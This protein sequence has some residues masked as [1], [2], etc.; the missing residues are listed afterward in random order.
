MLIDETGTQ[1]GAV[2]TYEAL[3]RARTAGLD[4]VEVAPAGR[5]P[6]CRIMDYGKYKYRQKKK[7]H[8]SKVSSHLKEVRLTPKIQEHDLLIKA[9]HAKDF[10]S[11][12]HK[13][14]VSMVFKGRE[15]EHMELGTNMLGVFTRSLDGICK[16]EAPA[17][18]E[19]KKLFLM[20]IPK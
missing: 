20:L 5:P 11:K 12:G 10:L 9:D 8:Q 13:V 19:G 3:N 1:I 2:D 14:L 15:M 7:E 16:V 4:L 18:R 17:R 6:V